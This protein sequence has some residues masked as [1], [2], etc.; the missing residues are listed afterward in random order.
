LLGTLIIR[1]ILGGLVV[2][3]FALI[4]EVLEPK[5]FAGLFGAA[6]SV[7]LATLGLAFAKESTSYVSTEGRSMIAGGV[8]F[9]GYALLVTWLLTRT[10]LA[11]WLAASLS[12]ALW[13]VI[14]FALWG[15]FLQ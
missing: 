9:F 5:S 13:L 1:F 12:W 3:A 2:S 11:S 10:R 14:G 15:A 6:P 7:A 8:A 4:G